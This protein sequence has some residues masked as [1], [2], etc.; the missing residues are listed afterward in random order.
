MLNQNL[1]D[2]GIPIRINLISSRSKWLLARVI[3]VIPKNHL[4]RRANQGHIKII[5]QFASRPWPC[6]AAGR[7]ARSPAK[8][9]SSSDRLRPMTT[10]SF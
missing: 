5:P 1:D 4:T 10:F 8:I 9:L 3:S 6:A 2:L 7:S